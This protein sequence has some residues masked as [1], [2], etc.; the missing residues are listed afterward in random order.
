MAF[1]QGLSFNKI[2]LIQARTTR[3]SMHYSVEV[4]QLV[5]LLSSTVQPVN[6]S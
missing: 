6:Y 4:S 2:L 1:T 5:S 3:E